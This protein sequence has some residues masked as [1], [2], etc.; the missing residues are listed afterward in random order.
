MRSSRS[1]IG[2]LLLLANPAWAQ[3]SAEANVA[4]APVALTSSDDPLTL[5]I[6]VVVLLVLLFLPMLL[7][8]RLQLRAA[9]ERAKRLETEQERF[10]E[11]LAAAPDGYYRW[12]LSP[13][14]EVLSEHC[15]RR[16][17]VLLGLFGGTGA[18]FEDILECFAKEDAQELEQMVRALRRQGTGFELELPLRDGN[19]RV[20]MLAN[21][22]SDA[23]GV[24]LA[25]L[26]WVRDITEG[27][28]AV[29][30]LAVEST[31]LASERDR[32]RALLDH[33]PMPVWMRDGDLALV[34]CNQ[35]YARAVDAV[36]PQAAVEA[37]AELVP[38]PAMR[39][40]LIH[41]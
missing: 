38:G 37:A 6:G 23:E 4:A 31:D 35:A 28:T 3:S 36:S 21:R 25:D 34:S 16:L 33:L 32:L 24:P 7:W 17:A 29:D 8:M 13:A 18:S 30:R 40:S 19:R 14:N 10:T 12:T 15:S 26:L 5:A 9:A 1:L 22:A 11:I 2:L 41:I 20:L 27:V 39:L